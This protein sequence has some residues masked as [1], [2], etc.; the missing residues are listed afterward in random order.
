MNNLDSERVKGILNEKKKRENAENKR[1][2]TLIKEK[3]MY[4]RGK[5]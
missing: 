1:V 2:K 3:I 5:R 4:G